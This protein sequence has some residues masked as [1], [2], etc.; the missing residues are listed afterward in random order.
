MQNS[1]REDLQGG[2]LGAALQEMALRADAEQMPGSPA[3]PML[4]LAEPREVRWAVDLWPQLR[5]CTKDTLHLANNLF[6]L[7]VLAAARGNPRGSR[8]SHRSCCLSAA[9]P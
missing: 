9:S 2:D 5:C 8:W 4:V 3:G 7:G 6:E 1:H